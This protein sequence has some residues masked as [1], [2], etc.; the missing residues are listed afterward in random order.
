MPDTMP[1][2]DYKAA[3]KAGPWDDYA[4]QSSPQ[5]S[6]PASAGGT[7]SAAPP[8]TLGRTLGLSVRPALEAVGGTTGM[9]GDALNT[10]INAAGG[11]I[12]HNPHLGMP[13]QLIQKGIDAILPKPATTTEKVVNALASMGYG[14]MGADPLANAISARLP[15]PQPRSMTPR[16]QSLTQAQ[17][18]GYALTPDQVPGTGLRGRLA[19]FVAGKKPLT[20]QAQLRNQNV[21]NQLAAKAAGLS[22]NSPLTPET[23]DAA[24]RAAYESGYA[25]VA[26]AGRMTNG[27]LYNKALDKVLNDFQGASASFPGAT[28]NDVAQ[29]VNGYRV[30]AFDAGDAIDAIRNLRADATA[31]Y[32]SGNTSLAKANS[33]IAQALEGSIEANLQTRG[34]PAA[35]MLDAYRAAR[36]QIAKTSEVGRAL[37]AGTGDVNAL[38][39]AAA[40]QKGKPLTGELQTIAQMGAVA[41]KLAATPTEQAPVSTLMRALGTGI[42]PIVAGAVMGP[43]AAAVTAGLPFARAGMRSMMLSPTGQGMIAPSAMNPG[44]LEQFLTSPYARGLPAAF[45]QSGLFGPQQ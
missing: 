22:P 40:L 43:H 4:N 17:Q 6:N 42:P 3:P 44:L 41:P 28:K 9:I 45:Q 35:Q 13:S 16:E 26:A 36:A 19:E 23:L 10:A 18:A 25:P 7:A 14:A 31:A 15:K 24:S 39:L 34:Q 38:K 30:R 11:A 21:T 32:K 5:Q 2:E 8:H 27:R 1:W 33:A 12:G 29:L 37:R 20:Q